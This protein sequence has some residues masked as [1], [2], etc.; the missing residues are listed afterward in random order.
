MLDDAQRGNEFI[1]IA[2]SFHIQSIPKEDLHERYCE[3]LERAIKKGVD[4]TLCY[5]ENNISPM[6]YFALKDQ[7][8][9]SAT[10]TK[11]AW[12]L[13]QERIGNKNAGRFVN[14]TLQALDDEH[15]RR[16]ETYFDNC[17]S[18]LLRLRAAGLEKE[19][20]YDE[21][22][23]QKGD[24]YAVFAGNMSS[25]DF[26]FGSFTINDAAPQTRRVT[27]IGEPV[28]SNTR[29]ELLETKLK[30]LVRDQ[31]GSTRQPLSPATVN[32]AT[33]PIVP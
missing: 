22:K 24:T 30:E 13:K 3:A 5:C 7:P 8:A 1:F 10:P 29:N 28:R 17:Y 16:R 26:L 6:E 11:A 27:C 21:N 32:A 23:L 2:P 20:V 31:I 9:G 25:R 18:F 33:A 14:W 12:E 15:R 19:M 4:V